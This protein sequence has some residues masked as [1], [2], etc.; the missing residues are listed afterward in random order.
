MLTQNIEVPPL[1]WPSY[2]DALLGRRKQMKEQFN[3]S[4]SKVH[5]AQCIQVT[6]VEK[7]AELNP[8]RTGCLLSRYSENPNSQYN[9]Y[10]KH[11][12]KRRTI[13]RIHVYFSTIV[14][15][16]SFLLTFTEHNSE[17]V[18]CIRDWEYI[19]SGHH[20]MS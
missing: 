20:R 12:S 18:C 19:Y 3:I 5:T 2:M 7:K 14:Q 9:N 1:S 8:K 16:A 11:I 10:Y 17:G 13:D 6:M 15:F 4:T